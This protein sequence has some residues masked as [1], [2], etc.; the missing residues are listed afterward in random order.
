MAIKL[1]WVHS[2]DVNPNKTTQ[3]PEEPYDKAAGTAA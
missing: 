2:I 3:K 1:T